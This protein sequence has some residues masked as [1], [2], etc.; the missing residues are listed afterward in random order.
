M[1]NTQD[2]CPICTEPFKDDEVLVRY[3]TWG[4]KQLA[5]KLG[6]LD[7]VLHLSKS[8]VRNHPP[9]PERR[10]AALEKRHSSAVESLGARITQL[11]G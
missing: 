3:V 7:C 6:H 8:E 9:S 1:S 2:I 5:E 11:G 10:I 4:K